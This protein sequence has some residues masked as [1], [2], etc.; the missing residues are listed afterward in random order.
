MTQKYFDTHADY[1][2]YNSNLESALAKITV[3]EEVSDDL[4]QEIET[5]KN[6][7]D[8]FLSRAINEGYISRIDDLY[9]PEAINDSARFGRDLSEGIALEQD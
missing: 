6:E 5:A 4:Y 9:N 7:W 1:S 2:F 8:D 3:G